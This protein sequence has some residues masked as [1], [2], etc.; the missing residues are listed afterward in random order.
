MRSRPAVKRE[1]PH[2]SSSGARSS[3]RT[4]FA[5]SLAERAAHKAALR[6]PTTITSYSSLTDPRSSCRTS[7]D[8]SIRLNAGS[9]DHLAPLLDLVVEELRKRFRPERIDDGA[10]RGELL[11]DSRVL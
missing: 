11:P 7:N 6:P 3:T 8:T 2:D 5:V 10:E 4:F 1:L 9:P